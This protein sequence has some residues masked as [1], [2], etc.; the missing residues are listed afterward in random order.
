MTAIDGRFGL[1]SVGV[2]FTLGPQSYSLQSKTSKPI[3][4]GTIQTINSTDV[5]L[6][7]DNGLRLTKNLI[8][9]PKRKKKIVKKQKGG[10]VSEPGIPIQQTD[11]IPDDVNVDPAH[12]LKSQLNAN[13]AAFYAY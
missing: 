10:G 4:Y 1:V 3:T 12:K 6:N 2:D 8:H 11:T 9:P 13:S 7:I 5:I